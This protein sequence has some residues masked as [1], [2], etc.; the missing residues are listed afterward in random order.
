MVIFYESS[1]Y[2]KALSPEIQHINII[3]QKLE[4]IKLFK[5]LSYFTQGNNSRD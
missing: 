1:S 4:T 3:D 5:E 2:L